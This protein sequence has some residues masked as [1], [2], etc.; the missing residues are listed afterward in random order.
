MLTDRHTYR[1]GKDGYVSEFTQFMDTLLEHHP[2]IV[3]DQHV[4][5]MKSWD[6]PVAVDE[7]KKATG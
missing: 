4:G 6:R 2:E 1:P 5:W 7:L 3:E